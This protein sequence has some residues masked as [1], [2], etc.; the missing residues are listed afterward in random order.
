MHK[1]TIVVLGLGYVGLPLALHFSK[2]YAT[3]GIDI[4]EK[5]VAELKSGFDRMGE[6]TAEQLKEAHIQYSTDLSRIKEGDIIIAAVPTPVDEHNIPDLTLVHNAARSIGKHIK[7]G[8]IAVF[9]ST[10]YP[11]V[12]EDECAP[13]IAQESGLVYNKDFFLGYSPER[14]NPGDH[15]HTIDKIIKIVSG[16]TPETA[17]T[18][19]EVYGTIVKAG[20]HVAPTIRVAEAAKVIENIQR[21]INIALVNELAILFDRLHINIYDVLEAAGTKWNFH[22]YTPGLVGG[23]CIGVDPYYL[24]YKAIE[25]NYHPNIILSGR[26]INDRMHS[27]YV[28]KIIKQ[29]NQKGIPSNKATIVILGLTFKENCTDYRNSRTEHLIK[30]LKEYGVK[31]YG[32]DPWL[33]PSIIEKFGAEPKTLEELKSLKPDAVVITVPH[34]QFKGIDLAGVPVVL[35]IKGKIVR[36]T[37]K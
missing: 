16:S 36:T 32:I 17:Q 1:P 30:D 28:E 6:A 5:K 15:E 9:E 23:H 2:H 18:L 34:N 29:L 14:I 31:L 4:N 21:D 8:A 13:I 3:I 11:G 12:T 35:D 20:I 7:K 27:F 10:V 19:K 26:R 22:R 24:T 25:V 37:H 33:E